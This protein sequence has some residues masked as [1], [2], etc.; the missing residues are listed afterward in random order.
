MIDAQTGLFTAGSIDGVTVTVLATAVADP[1]RFKRA[2]VT[3][4]AA[5]Q[6]QTGPAPARRVARAPGPLAQEDQCAPPAPTFPLAEVRAFVNL[7][8]LG[9]L[10]C[11]PSDFVQPLSDIV[12]PAGPG[13]A[14]VAVPSMSVSANDEDSGGSASASGQANASRSITVASGGV[15][16]VAGAGSADASVAAAQGGVGFARADGNTRVEFTLSASHAFVIDAAVTIT[17]DV[18]AAGGGVF[19]IDQARGLRVVE[20]QNAGG[21]QGGM[22]PP[23]TYQVSGAAGA[24][25]SQIGMNV[26]GATYSFTLT[27]TPP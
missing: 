21:T 12:A 22:L 23:G 10:D 20:F 5:A 4:C 7:S 24:F 9:C 11:P 8:A 3:V 19:I 18:G 2:S 1:A 6:P 13:S 15:V 27:L 17:G 25:L 16:T 14:S 26:T